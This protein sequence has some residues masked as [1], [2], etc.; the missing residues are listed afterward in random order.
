MTS[1]WPGGYVANL[2]LTALRAVP[3]WSV[4]WNDPMV[5]S[6]ANSWGMKCTV[7]PK[8]SVTCTGSDWTAKL[9]AGQKVTVGLQVN[10]GKAPVN[11]AL[12]IR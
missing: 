5:T 3:S 9:A 2:D 1:S 11:P 7:V 6:V 4:S 10:A 12:T 8:T